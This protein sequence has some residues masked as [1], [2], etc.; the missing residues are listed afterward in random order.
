ML[1]GLGGIGS[2]DE[3][4]FASLLAEMCS[5][6]GVRGIDQIAADL[7]EFLWTPLYRRPATEGFWER[8]DDAQRLM[9]NMEI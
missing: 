7:E 8:V 4:Y 6:I 2:S 5:G 9:G 1:G 3:Q